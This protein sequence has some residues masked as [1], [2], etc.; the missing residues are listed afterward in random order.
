MSSYTVLYIFLGL[1]LALAF[2]YY[3]Y[4]YKTN[5][6]GIVYRY[7]AALR[8]FTFFLIALLFINPLFKKSSYT[9]E[10]P[11]LVIAVD[12]SQSI[13]FLK[14]DKQVNSIF[15][16]LKSDKEL[17]KKF[18]IQTFTFGNRLQQSDSLTFKESQTKIAEALKK[19]SNLYSKNTSLLLITDANQT[20]GLDYA[21]TK[22]NFPVNAFI[23]G[24]TSKLVD[25]KISRV[26][27]NE[28]TYLGNN[29]PVEIFINYE[30]IN[31]VNSTLKIFKNTR[32]IYTKKLS[33]NPD[34]NSKI[35]RFNLKTKKVGIHQYKAVIDSIKGEKNLKNNKIHFS[36][37]TLNERSNILIYST[38]R[39]PDIG[40][41]RRS[42]ESNKQ[43][44]VSVKIGRLNIDELKEYQLVIIYQPSSEMKSLFGKLKSLNKPYFIITGSKTD[45]QFLNK[46]QS[47]F[48]KN[49]INQNQEYF[50]ELNKSFNPFV[51]KNID[52]NDFPPLESKFGGISFKIPHQTLLYQK[53]GLVSTQQPLL[54]T[55][56]IGNNKGAV[57]FG[58]NIW[59]WRM[60]HFTV[61]ENFKNFDNF[62]N[63]IV[64]YL[65]ELKSRSQLKVS[66]KS[67][68]YANQ[69]VEFWA[70]Y[71]DATKKFDS[72]AKL[73]LTISK[74]N[75]VLKSTYPMALKSEK[76]YLSPSNLSAGR[77]RFTVKD[78]KSAL[79]QKGNFIVLNFPIEHQ[80]YNANYKKLDFLTR[81]N[82]G[83]IYMLSDV[84]KFK[85]DILSNKLFKSIQKKSVKTIPLLSFKWLLLLIV[86]SAV[87]EWFLRKYHGLI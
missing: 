20:Q 70:S 49:Y 23:A 39:H 29:F 65:T 67:V 77:Y 40:A 54:A 8:A 87:T 7:L 47:V 78:K 38:I 26:N 53:I 36:T 62:I 84:N 46:I 45:W 61:Y 18:A 81:K 4:F 44:K 51:V 25:I 80:F 52:F 82:D 71:L 56:K 17:S 85:S 33:F 32:L 60:T 34:E 50:A 59:K 73:E 68:V 79:S 41:L 76:Y 63:T 58:E 35:V 9:I 74:E 75:S 3:Q 64:Q 30:D 42:I 28:Y 12:N 10:K 5:Y 43:R 6:E 72:R 66:Y 31:R 21:F 69:P 24:D 48:R 2:S 83:K 11:N 55:F 19:V 27:T 22:L 14:A 16:R 86:I 13:A 57:L 15:N 1:G 37:T